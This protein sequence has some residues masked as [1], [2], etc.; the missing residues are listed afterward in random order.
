M[1]FR[2]QAPYGQP[3]DASLSHHLV[4]C[5]NFVWPLNGYLVGLNVSSEHES[6]QCTV[7][8]FDGLINSPAVAQGNE[9]NVHFCVQYLLDKPDECGLLL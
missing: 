5:I 4:G 9:C 6:T 8:E 3:R 1:S 2:R 7:Y